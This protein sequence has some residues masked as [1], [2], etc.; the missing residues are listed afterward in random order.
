MTAALQ[1]AQHHN[2]AEVANVQRVCRRVSTQV[3]RYHLLL[4]QFLGTGHHLGQHT[5]PAQFFYK[6]F[7]IFF[8]LLCFV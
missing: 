5:T 7:H 3:G 1:V 6:V 2:A 8:F 4:E